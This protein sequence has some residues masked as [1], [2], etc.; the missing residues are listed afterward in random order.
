MSEFLNDKL[1]RRF[2]T[3]DRDGNG[4]L[5]RSDFVQ[6]ADRLGDAFNR[7]A[8]SPQRQQMREMC[9]RLWEGLR[10]FA[11]A[12]GD[13]RVSEAEYRRAFTELIVKQPGAFDAAYAPF[14]STLMAMADHDGDGRLD[15]D[16]Y[17]SWFVTAFGITEHDADTAFDKVD[18]DGDGHVTEEE[19][20]AAIRDYYFSNDP[21]ASGNWLLGPPAPQK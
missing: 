12:D 17:R 15:R 3:W 18:A 16:E 4:Y 14:V 2:R 6:G 5:E 21:D 13:G 9:Q 19:M 20:V 7:P 8:D 11:D 1:S 10:K